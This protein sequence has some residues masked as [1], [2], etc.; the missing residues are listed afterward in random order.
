MYFKCVCLLTVLTTVCAPSPHTF[1]LIGLYE[2]DYQSN[3][4]ATDSEW[5]YLNTDH[6]EQSPSVGDGYYNDLEWD[7]ERAWQIPSVVYVRGNDVEV[8]LKF[9]NP[10]FV[11][12]SVSVVV[13]NARLAV[14]PIAP[15]TM[16]TYVTL[17]DDGPFTLTLGAFGGSDT[18]TM[19][20]SGLPNHVTNGIL[21]LDM[22]AIEAGNPIW[23][24][25]GW[26]SWEKLYLTYDTPTASQEVPWTDVLDYSCTWARG[27]STLADVSRRETFG[28]YWG[29]VFAY[30]LGTEGIPPRWIEVDSPHAGEFML[31]DFLADVGGGLVD[32]SCV[33]ISSFMQILLD[34]QGVTSELQRL[35]HRYSL[36]PVTDLPFVTNLVCPIGSN[37]SDPGLYF[38]LPFTMHQQCKTSAGV[39]DA[40][41]AFE[42]DL[43]GSG[44]ANPPANWPMDD[45]WQKDAGLTPDVFYGLVYRDV[46]GGDSF[47]SL[48][49][50]MPPWTVVTP[51]TNVGPRAFAHTTPLLY[52]IAGVF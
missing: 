49:P 39:C 30:N 47:S 11:S 14:P 12:R 24:T 50:P 35:R 7:I 38:Q 15:S 45:Y 16:W 23:S 17:G 40:A 3:V 19:T 29:E 31:S 46:V 25:Q 52:S 28:L 6:S 26:A 51:D 33:D 21:Q 5:F 9:V 36:N 44:Y 18:A 48:V 8:D 4:R 27:E 42:V 20:L 37:G 22:E 1:Q 32:G 34:S 43:S 41:L 10:G 2:R 13:N